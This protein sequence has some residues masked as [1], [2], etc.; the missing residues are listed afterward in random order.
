MSESISNWVSGRYVYLET[1]EAERAAHEATKA[2]LAGL[3]AGV[4]ALAA[5]WEFGRNHMHDAAA[6][7]SECSDEL[8]TLLGGAK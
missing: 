7:M 1:L 2:E 5:D 3:R 6:V 4:E 8:R